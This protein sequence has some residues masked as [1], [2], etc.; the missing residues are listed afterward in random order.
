[1]AVRLRDAP[2]P[3]RPAHADRAGGPAAGTS[4]GREPVRR[5]FFRHRLGRRGRGRAAH[6]LRVGGGPGPFPAVRRRLRFAGIAPRNRVGSRGGDHRV[7]LRRCD[8]V[9]RA[10]D[11]LAGGAASSHRNVRGRGSGRGVGLSALSGPR[12]RAA[13]CDPRLAV[14][15]EQR[16]VPRAA[17]RRHQGLV[18]Q[19]RRAHGGAPPRALRAAEHRA[20]RTVAADPVDRRPHDRSTALEPGV[21]VR[22]RR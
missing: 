16:H 1:M 2:D 9:G 19:P 10:G 21:L 12:R 15:D 5:P 13:G 3:S 22:R 6:R 17:R 11:G 4:P 7:H 14:A 20:D 18:S 8:P